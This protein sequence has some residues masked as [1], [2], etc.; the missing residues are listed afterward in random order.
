MFIETR[1]ICVIKQ[2]R[3]YVKVWCKDCNREVNMVSPAEAALM[4]FQDTKTIY[5]LIDKKHIHY[6]CLKPETPLVC[7]RSLFLI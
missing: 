4:V 5:S 1:E 3:I 2:K 7:L 6:R